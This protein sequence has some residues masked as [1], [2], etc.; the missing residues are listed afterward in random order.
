MNDVI[1]H[2]AHYTGITIRGQAVECIDVIEALNLP[3]HLANALKYIWRYRE[4]GGI[5]DIRKAGWYCTRFADW[6][7]AQ[8]Q[9]AM[10]ASDPAPE[11]P[12]AGDVES[13]LD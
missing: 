10:A 1:N 2:P 12:H 5:H 11:L 9:M 3:P 4:K 13:E 7:D 6:Q 8:C